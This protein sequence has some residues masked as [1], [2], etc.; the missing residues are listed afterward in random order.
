M[1]LENVVLAAQNPQ[2]SIDPGLKALCYHGIVIHDGFYAR[3]R[4]CGQLFRDWVGMKCDA[5]IAKTERIQIDAVIMKG[6]GVKGLAYAGAMRELEKYYDFAGFV[7]TSAGS[8]A[9]VLLAAGYDGRDLEDILRK[10]NFRNF[11]DGK[12]FSM[13]LNLFIH[14]GLH[15]G[16]TIQEWIRNLL[17]ARTGRT[18]DIPLKDFAPKRVVIYAS[19]SN[20]GTVPFDSEGQ[21]QDTPAFFAVRCSMS[22]PYFFQPQMLEGSRV[23]DGGLLNNYP[24]KTY[25]EEEHKRHPAQRPKFIALYLGSKNPRPLPKGLL[26]FDML[27]ILFDRDDLTVI[28]EYR[29]HTLV[30]DPSPITTV[31]FTLSDA[32][33][34]LLVLQG[35]V[36]AL[37]YIQD[38][39]FPDGPSNHEVRQVTEQARETKEKVLKAR[40]RK[41]V[42]GYIISILLVCFII[43][44]SSAVFGWPISQIRLLHRPMG[45]QRVTKSRQ[46]P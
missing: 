36:A 45:T 6:G 39:G 35:R 11:M 14:K 10:T 2:L 25:L 17:Y 37:Q 3:Y 33:K 27:N 43:V 4:V 23:L 42:W 34:D 16:T 8:I 32:E 44:S 29:E 12:G 24:V 41:K 1:T 18:G 20:G 21:R 46:V 22:I 40:R 19:R 38:Q 15:P 28:D 30:I 7:G 5:S 9:A 26:L 31:D 13:I